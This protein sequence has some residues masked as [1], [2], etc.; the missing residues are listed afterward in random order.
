MLHSSETGQ[1]KSPRKKRSK[2]V[3]GVVKGKLTSIG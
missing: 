1:G 3:E 2:G